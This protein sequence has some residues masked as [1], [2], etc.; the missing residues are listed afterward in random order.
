MGVDG[1]SKSGINSTALADNA[2]KQI[3]AIGTGQK[4]QPTEVIITN[5]HATEYAYVRIFDEA[6]GTPTANLQKIPQ[7]IIPPLETIIE[8]FVDAYKFET[9]LSAELEGGTGTVDAYDCQ[10][11]GK[12]F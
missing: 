1:I 10:V 4:F 8:P 12:M 2:T 6:A 3:I 11:N 5:S 9:E 7:I